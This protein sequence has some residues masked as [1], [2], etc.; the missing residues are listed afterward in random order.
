VIKV[1]FYSKLE[2]ICSRVPKYEMLII[3]RDFNA[4]VGREECRHKV[5]GKYSLHEHSN[6][7]GLFL[8]QFAI[9]NNL[10]IKCTTF[11]HKAIHIGTWKISGSM[12]VNQID[13]VLVPARHASS[14]ID[15]RNSSGAK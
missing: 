8:V 10:Y 15:V 7:N 14:I 2:R 9:R 3:M 6:E 4:K 13:H 5:S 12:E 1:E 11:P